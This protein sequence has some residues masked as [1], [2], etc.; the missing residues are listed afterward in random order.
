MYISLL[1]KNRFKVSGE[2][3]SGRNESQ[4]KYILNNRRQSNLISFDVRVICNDGF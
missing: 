3:N 1:L 4:E 2:K